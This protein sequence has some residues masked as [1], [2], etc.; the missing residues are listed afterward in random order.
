M[1]SDGSLRTFADVQE[2]ADDKVAGRAAIHKKQVVMLETSICK[3]V[4]LVDLP[5]QPHHIGDVV[6]AEVGEVSF[7][8]M[9]RVTCKRYT[10]IDECFG[11]RA[12]LVVQRPVYQ[13]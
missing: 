9:E 3:A 8:G 7:W 11:R 10:I 13:R 4:A 2:A 6:L 12:L 5:I 1:D